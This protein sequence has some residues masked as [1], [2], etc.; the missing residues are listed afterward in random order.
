MQGRKAAGSERGQ[1]TDG[2][3]IDDTS[4]TAIDLS[5]GAA[6][7]PAS[8]VAIPST[9]E[10]LHIGE[11]AM[12]L[13]SVTPRKVGGSNKPVSTFAECALAGP[14]RPG[15]IERR[16]TVNGVEFS[17]MTARRSMAISRR[18]CCG[19]RVGRLEAMDGD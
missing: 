9:A 19:H 10:Y 11:I 5:T 1:V 2:R 7:N 18:Q 3:R 6:F 16:I 4:M 8:S 13:R 14:S 12:R 17:S 15:I